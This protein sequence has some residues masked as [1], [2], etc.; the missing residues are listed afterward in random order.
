MENLPKLH[1]S[2][3]LQNAYLGRSLKGIYQPLDGSAA[4]IIVGG[5]KLHSS[6]RDP[7]TFFTSF[8][9][10]GVTRCRPFEGI[11]ISMVFA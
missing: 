4:E 6:F 10:A 1:R 7:T 8:C 9:A 3:N 2:D 5:S 11:Q